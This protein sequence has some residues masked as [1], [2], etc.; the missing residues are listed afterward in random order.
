M[1]LYFLQES[2]CIIKINNNN[3]VLNKCEPLVLPE[4]GVLYS[5]R[6]NKARTVQQQEQANPS[7]D[8]TPA[9]TTYI[10]HT[11]THTHHSKSKVQNEPVLSTR[12]TL[13][14]QPITSTTGRPGNQPVLSTKL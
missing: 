12:G 10:T 11:H 1:Q 4:L 2:K 3:E 6:R 8:S 7:V 13:R 5:K 14:S 9:D